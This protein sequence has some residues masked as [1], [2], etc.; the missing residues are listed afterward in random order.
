M[1]NL[2]TF[3]HRSQPYVKKV[4]CSP[5][6]RTIDHPSACVKH[7]LYLGDIPSGI[8]KLYS[9][10]TPSLLNNDD[11]HIFTLQIFFMQIKDIMTKVIILAR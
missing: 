1:M 10:Y 8:T 6:H 5:R 11:Y 7:T 4:S 9:E 2:A 3:I